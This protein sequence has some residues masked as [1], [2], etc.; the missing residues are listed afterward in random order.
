MTRGAD[1]ICMDFKL[2]EYEL[3]QTSSLR[4]LHSPTARKDELVQKKILAAGDV[5]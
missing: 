2:D 3:G 5:R 1:E 4:P